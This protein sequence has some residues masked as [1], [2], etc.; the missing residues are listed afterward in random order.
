MS[1]LVEQEWGNCECGSLVL[2]LRFKVKVVTCAPAPQFVSCRPARGREI[3]LPPV[4]RVYTTGGWVGG[5]GR[6]K[7][8]KVVLRPARISEHSEVQL[9]FFFFLRREK[10]GSPGV[11]SGF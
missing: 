6:E 3:F 8:K 7:K 9:S 5:K 10:P 2:L 11:E 1:T 4:A